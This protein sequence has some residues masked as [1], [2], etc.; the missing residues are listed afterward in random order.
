M[1]GLF[2]HLTPTPPQAR[3]RPEVKTQ[4]QVLVPDFRL[5]FGSS[6]P[7]LDLAPGETT[8]RLAEIKYADG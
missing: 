8:I 5:Q 6:T 3:E 2:Q 1:T 4:S 7:G